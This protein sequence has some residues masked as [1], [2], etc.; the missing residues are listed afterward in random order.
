MPAYSTVEPAFCAFADEALS[1]PAATLR[2]NALDDVQGTAP[3]PNGLLMALAVLHALPVTSASDPIAPFKLSKCCASLALHAAPVSATPS[4]D[5]HRPP[6]LPAS[7][8]G[9]PFV[10]ASR[11]TACC[12]AATCAGALHPFS[13][14]VVL[15]SAH[16]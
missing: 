7:S 5:R 1:P 14:L 8:T 2:T 4:S 12:A 3:P 15:R 11:A 10:C 13:A 9:T 16:A 6:S